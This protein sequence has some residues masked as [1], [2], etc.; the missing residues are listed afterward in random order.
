MKSILQVF[1]NRHMINVN[2]ISYRYNSNVV[3]SHTFYPYDG[4]NCAKYVTEL[5][6][7]EECEYSDETPFAPIITVV[8]ELKPKIPN[9][10]HGCE[11][12]ISSSIIEPFVFY[13]TES[14]SFN[15][16]VEVLMT[17]TIAEALKMTPVF[18]RNN[19]TRENRVVSNDTGIYANLLTQ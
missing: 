8:D 12:H 1:L 10:L 2:V 17:K 3:Q 6:L 4:V 11:M 9:D 5:Y 15:T 13:D 18:T 7:I 19:D 14:N 16:G